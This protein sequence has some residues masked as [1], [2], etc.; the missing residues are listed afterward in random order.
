[1]T[2]GAQP[3]HPDQSH[4]PNEGRDPTEHAPQ[5]NE[6]RREKRKKQTGQLSCLC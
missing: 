5:N 3:T 6:H 4:P 1:M 2:L